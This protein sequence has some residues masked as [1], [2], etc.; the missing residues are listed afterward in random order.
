M[1]DT[2]QKK[3]VRTTRETQALIVQLIQKMLGRGYHNSDIEPAI[4]KK[5]E[6]SHRSV[7]RYITR[8]RRE[9]REEVENYLEHHRVDSFFFYRS[10]IENPKAVERDRIRARERIDK[11]LGLDTQAPSEKDLSNYTLKELNKMSDEEFDAVY[12]KELDRSK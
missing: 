6:I 7:E 11:L 8:A 2:P 3:R 12:Q 5:F 1:T 4:T 9:M 10:V